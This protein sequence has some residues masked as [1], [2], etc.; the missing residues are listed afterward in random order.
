MLTSLTTEQI[1]MEMHYSI[2]AIEK[3][4]GTRPRY[5]RYPL[6]D[7]GNLYAL[8]RDIHIHWGL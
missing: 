8:I 7:A 5:A 1:V 2:L 4:I 3:V 6:G